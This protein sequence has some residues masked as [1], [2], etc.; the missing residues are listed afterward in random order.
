MNH[1]LR[2]GIAGLGTVG[3][4]L[5]TL[6]REHGARLAGNVGLSAFKTQATL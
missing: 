4:G 6:L 3:G 2:L 5:L 1:P